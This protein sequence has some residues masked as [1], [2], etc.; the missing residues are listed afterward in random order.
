VS[1]TGGHVQTSQA[2]SSCHSSPN[3]PAGWVLASA[4]ARFADRT[5]QQICNTIRT[6]G[7]LASEITWRNHVTED[8]LIEW[9]FSP[10]NKN[11]QALSKPPRD[12][13]WFGQKSLDLYDPATKTL[14]CPSTL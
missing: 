4:N 8:K 5:V 9:A 10:K 2:C 14:F 1:G 6:S 3:Y 13:Q 7:F 12:F 11:G